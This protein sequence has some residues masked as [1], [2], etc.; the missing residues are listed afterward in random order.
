MNNENW[1]SGQQR[2]QGQAFPPPQQ[3]P[4]Q[5]QPMNQWQQPQHPQQQIPPHGQPIPPH[6]MHPPIQPAKTGLSTGAKWGIGCGVAAL[7]GFLIMCGAFAVMSILWAADNQRFEQAEYH[8]VGGMRVD[9]VRS[10]VGH[11]EIVYSSDSDSRR[12]HTIRLEYVDLSS[13]DIQRYFDHLISQGFVQEGSILRKDSPDGSGT[14]RVES[15][16]P[17]L[18][19]FTGSIYIQYIFE[20]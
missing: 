14:L 18:S 4:P 9:S 6:M 5:Q 16:T 13:E 17:Q 15:M 2:V 12:N 11:R 10:V 7:V 3:Q 19:F 8:V 1:N 20:R